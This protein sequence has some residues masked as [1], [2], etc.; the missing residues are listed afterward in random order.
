VPLPARLYFG[1]GVCAGVGFSA[2]AVLTRLRLRFRIME[3]ESEANNRPYRCR[4]QSA[5]A[6]M[7]TR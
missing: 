2:G 1:C 3:L 7:A 5:Q 6:S 4:R